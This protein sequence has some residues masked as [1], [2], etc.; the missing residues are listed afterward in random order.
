MFPHVKIPIVV[1]GSNYPLENKKS[2]GL[3]NF[4]N[5]VMFILNSRLSGIY[6]IF[7]D[8]RGK[9]IVFLGSRIREAD[10]YEDQ[11]SSYGGSPL[12]EIVDGKFKLYNS[13][14]NPA[15]ETLLKTRNR[16]LYHDITFEHEISAMQSYPGLN[17]DNF[18][19]LKKPKAILH[20]LYHSGTG[21]VSNNY[22]SLPQF[23]ERCSKERIDLFNIIS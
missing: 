23:I 18:Q 2:V 9:N 16:V 11:F 3:Y 21:C 20:S 13:L 17:Y 5:A 14:I 4:Y 22:F 6:S 8:N 10:S 12:G 15:M 1:T 19:F 7:Q